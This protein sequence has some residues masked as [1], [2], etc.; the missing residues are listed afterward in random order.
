MLSN[1]YHHTEDVCLGSHKIVS[2]A[3]TSTEPKEQVVKTGRERRRER[4]K[5]KR[6][7]N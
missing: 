6:N 3:F 7:A 4:R 1:L 5:L 2:I